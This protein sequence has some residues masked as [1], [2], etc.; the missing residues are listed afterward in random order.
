MYLFTASKNFLRVIK[1][2]EVY[3]GWYYLCVNIA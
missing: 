3:T 1:I 2:A